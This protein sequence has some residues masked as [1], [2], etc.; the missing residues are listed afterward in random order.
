[1]KFYFFRLKWVIMF[2]RFVKDNGGKKLRTH[3]TVVCLIKSHNVLDAGPII[4]RLE[5]TQKFSSKS[6]RKIIHVQQCDVEMGKKRQQ[7][8]QWN[9]KSEFFR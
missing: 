8:L 6:V 1:M 5:Q 9:A 2:L 3:L 4:G 7:K